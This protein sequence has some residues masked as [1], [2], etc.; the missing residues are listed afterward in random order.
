MSPNEER[1][2]SRILYTRPYYRTGYLIFVRKNGPRISH[3]TEL[4]GEQTRRVG[5]Q[6]GA[7]ADFL[8]RQRGF[9]R[10]LYGSQGAALKALAERRIDYA[11]LWSNSVWMARR[12]PELAVEFVQPYELEDWRH[13]A[14]AVRRGDQ[15][16]R[17][18][19][20][21]AIDQ[22]IRDKFIE[23]LLSRYGVPYYRPVEHGAKSAPV[24]KA[25][26]T[27]G[28]RSESDP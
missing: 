7:L 2:A 10:K 11:Y 19:L 17:R 16:F 23:R 9:Q 27:S 22:L 24:D 5:A 1:A 21:Q 12:S 15:E 28:A 14:G 4:E 13:M 18:Q 8:L 25:P 26:A 6:A 3:L 20:N